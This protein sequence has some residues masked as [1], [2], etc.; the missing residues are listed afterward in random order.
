MSHIY[1]ITAAYYQNLDPVQRLIESYRRNDMEVHQFGMGEPWRGTVGGD[2]HAQYTDAPQFIRQAP[3]GYD[4]I[5]FTDATDCFMLPGTTE[6]EI[7]A[8]FERSGGD[9]LMSAEPHLY[10]PWLHDEYEA[11][12]PKRP[13]VR[14]PFRCPNI[15]GW[16]GKRDA[17]LR[18]LEWCRDNYG[19]ITHEGQARGIMAYM[20]GRFNIRLDTQCSVFQ[21]MS[22]GAGGMV[23]WD[24]RFLHNKMTDSYPCFVHFNGRLGGIE[25]FWEKAY[26]R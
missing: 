21:C 15:G 13:E 26:G 17:V 22:G 25:E 3:E 20:D 14:T 7:V 11:I 2:T 12:F 23:E 19:E 1:A 16:L 6:Y 4:L 18:Y 9:I 24:G 5:L 10:P 8:A